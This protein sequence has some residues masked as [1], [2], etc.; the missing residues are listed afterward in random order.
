MVNNINKP[1]FEDLNLLIPKAGLVPKTMM[2]VDNID[3]K[4]ALTVYLWNLLPPELCK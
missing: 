2:F 4:I 3:N 1:G